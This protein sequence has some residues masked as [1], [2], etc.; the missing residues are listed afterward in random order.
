MISNKAFTVSLLTL[1]T[2]VVC[3]IYGTS[4]LNE[5][6]QNRENAKEISEQK[7]FEKEE[8]KKIATQRGITTESGMKAWVYVNSLADKREQWTPDSLV[9]AFS[10][11]ISETEEADHAEVFFQTMAFAAS[12]VQD[13]Y[14][15]N[16]PIPEK[17]LPSLRN[18]I[19]EGLTSDNATVRA[20]AV[21]AAIGIDKKKIEEAKA[22]GVKPTNLEF[23]NLK[24]AVQGDKNALKI[25]SE[26]GSD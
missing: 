5:Y 11:N 3:Y 8:Y 7:A 22:K 12:F 21:W 1:L 19:I 15:S 14:L 2:I 18:L 23:P 16:V 10:K 26:E 13:C 4:A 20:N 24:S 6:K 25:I 9:E 17:V